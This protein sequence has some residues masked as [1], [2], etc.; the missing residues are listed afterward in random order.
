ML[1]KLWEV[2]DK[3]NFNFRDVKMKKKYILELMK[4]DILEFKILF[5]VKFFI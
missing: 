1:I 3:I 2:I 4:Y 5:L